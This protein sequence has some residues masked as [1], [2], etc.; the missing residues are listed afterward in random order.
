MSVVG[1]LIIC[2]AV[3][4]VAFSVGIVAGQK[5]AKRY[6]TSLLQDLEAEALDT[7]TRHAVSHIVKWLQTCLRVL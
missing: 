2:V 7:D 5:I 6:I 4:V 3:G 1:Q